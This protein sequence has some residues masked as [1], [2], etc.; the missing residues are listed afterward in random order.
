MN[1]TAVE[2]AQLPRFCWGQLQVPNANGE[3]FWIRDC[4]PAANHYCSGL[5]YLVRA[6]HSA[7]K[8]TRLELVLHADTDVAY[9]ERAIKDYPQCSIREDVARSRAEVNNLIFMYG[10]KRPGAR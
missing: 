7:H 10:G 4:G 9:T 6:K 3:E 8:S 2:I 1:V 5:I